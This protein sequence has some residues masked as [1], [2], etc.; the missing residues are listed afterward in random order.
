VEVGGL[1]GF[2]ATLSIFSHS[3]AKAIEWIAANEWAFWLFVLY[4]A[5]VRWFVYD[6]GLYDD[7]RFVVSKLCDDSRKKVE[8]GSSRKLPSK[9]EGGS[10]KG[11]RPPKRK[12]R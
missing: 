2:I 9:V 7:H 12:R 3:L 11:N 5:I 6:R 8:N 1:T 10:S 4:Y